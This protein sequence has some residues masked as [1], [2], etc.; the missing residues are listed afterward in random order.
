MAVALSLLFDAGTSDVIER[1]WR[2]L[3]A[4]EISSDMLDLG[5]PPHLTLVVADDEALLPA[6]A[7]SL[8]DLAPLVPRQVRLGG[9]SGFPGTSVVYLECDGDLADVHRAAADCVP[10]E[11][12]R[13]YYRPGAWTP[14]VTLQTAG[15]PVAAA[16]VAKA[17]WSG[18]MVAV[19]V[20]LELAAFVPVEVKDGVNLFYM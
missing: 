15:D 4:A 7:G 18:G 6:F 16:A 11:S 17:H 3:S 12:I 8:N 1:I 9:V 10:L 14:H 19:P 20:R 5:Y 2:A 13:P